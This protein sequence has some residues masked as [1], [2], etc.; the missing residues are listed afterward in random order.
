MT[1]A[2]IKS[3]NPAQNKWINSTWTNYPRCLV[4]LSR[5]WRAAQ[6]INLIWTSCPIYLGEWPRRQRIARGRKGKVLMI[7][8]V[9]GLNYFL[10]LTCV[11]MYR[12]HMYCIYIWMIYNLRIYR[13]IWLWWIFSI[14][15][16]THIF[17]NRRLHHSGLSWL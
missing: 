13:K 10:V 3:L 5:R 14:R 11:L 1:P 7:R 4:G 12:D 15:Y 9:T 6:R 16:Q 17:S 2:D 8:R